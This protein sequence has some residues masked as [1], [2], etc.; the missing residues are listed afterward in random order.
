VEALPR[1]SPGA[2]RDP[3]GHILV[4]EDQGPDGTAMGLPAWGPAT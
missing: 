4:L 2:L 3:D 1:A